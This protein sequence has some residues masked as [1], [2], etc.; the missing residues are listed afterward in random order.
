MNDKMKPFKA[1]VLGLAVMLSALVLLMVKSGDIGDVSVAEANIAR[2][3]I[4]SVSS[5][6]AYDDVDASI[7]IV[8]SQFG[9]EEPLT[10]TLG[11][12]ELNVTFSEHI[13]PPEVHS[14][15]I[16][17]DA[18]S[19]A[20]PAVTLNVTATNDANP[21]GLNAIKYIE[22]EY[23]LGAQKW[24]VVNQSGW[25]DYETSRLNYPWELSTTYG[26]RYM[27]A[28]VKDNDNNISQAPGT[29]VISL[30]P[31][32]VEASIEQDEVHFFRILLEEGENFSATLTP[33]SG[34]PDLY[35]WAANAQLRYDQPLTGIESVSFE[36]PVKGI[37]QIQVYGYT[38]SDYTLSFGTTKNLVQAVPPRRFALTSGMHLPDAPNVSIDRV[39]VSPVVPRPPSQGG[40]SIPVIDRD[41]LSAPERLWTESWPIRVGYQNSGVGL[42]VQHLGNQ[43]TIDQVTVEFRLGSVTGTLLGRSQT[44][45]IGPEEIESSAKVVW[46]PDMPGEYTVCAIIDPDNEV[47]EADESNNTVCRTLTVLP[48]GVDVVL[49]EVDS[50]VI[51]DDA[52]STAS[53]AV[54]LNVTATDYPNPGASGLNA[55]K[56]VE[57]EYI[58]E[59]ERWVPVQRTSWIT[60]TTASLNY[61]WQLISTYGMRYMEAWVADNQGN[62]S[63]TPGV[64]I[65]NY[66]PEATDAS[67]AQ[68]GIHFYC[69]I[70]SQ[71]DI[72]S[73]TLTAS[74]GDPDL[75]V[76][77]PSEQLASYSQ[78]VLTEVD[79]IT[80]VAPNDGTYLIEVHGYQDSDYRLSFGAPLV[81]AVAQRTFAVTGPKPLPDALSMPLSSIPAACPPIRTSDAYEP[82]DS[83]QQASSIATDGTIEAHTFHKRADEDWVRFDGTAGTT[84]SIEARV[85]DDSL[86]DVVLQLYDACGGSSTP[87]DSFGPTVRLQFEAIS[88][89]PHYINLTN[90]DPEATGADVNYQLS[91][92]ALNEEPA[93]G[94][95]VL[96][97]G[98]LRA[99]DRLQSNIHQVTNKVYNLFLQ[100][101]YT[102][103]RIYYLATDF[104]LNADNNPATQDVDALA[105]RERLQYAIT[106]WATDE[107]L[108][109][110]ADR[111]FTLYMMDHGDY[112]TLYLNTSAEQVGPDDLDSWLSTLEAAAPG[113]TVNVIVDACLAG[114]FIDPTLSLSKPG[115]LVIASTTNSSN[116][117]ASQEGGAIFSDSFVQALDQEMSL[118]SAFK[119]AQEVA[120]SW[121]P[122]QVAWLDD[123]GDGQAN[124]NA[125]GQVAQQR[126]FAYAG[127]FAGGQEPP[128][129]AWANG[130]TTIDNRRG[131]IEAHVRDDVPNST[132][133]VWAVIYEPSYTP[134]PPGR[135]IVFEESL[136]TVRLQ[137]PDGDNVY[138]GEFAGFD[139]L[140]SYR[141]VVYAVD[142][143]GLQSRPRTTLVQT[144]Y[145]LYLPAIT[146]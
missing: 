118:Y 23:V 108:G 122:D 134:P 21:G 7:A 55:I 35:V 70:L 129:I 43:Q 67:I 88:S 96:V 97:A 133:N 114:S 105:N 127:S 95:L 117:Y 111:A 40:Q 145:E 71:D 26:T 30:L 62:V 46:E 5:T 80:F 36:A 53:P 132:L 61:P 146:R 14:F 141:I 78:N 15:V 99:N 48:L 69:V 87:Y 84:Y 93:P 10:V 121:H 144:G 42:L 137:D 135:E 12:Q 113:V 58:Y 25:L 91:V 19:T 138:S 3:V 13:M 49:P 125:D 50:F 85:P 1:S 140:G 29:D 136:P 75:Y 2:P 107:S 68:D 63:A 74:T 8:G 112:D 119:E 57:Y 124:G 116:A 101:G 52:P 51:A 54:T 120:Q 104:N 39:P 92:R 76:W 86:A 143:N 32:D 131:Q 47:E 38:A 139:Q 44:N 31:Q 17:D 77:G 83:C 94:A 103:D 72:F 102:A 6:W 59:V 66:L 37:Y 20:S 4:G 73:A 56:Y 82:N 18:T 27:Q 79:S 126:G 89:G 16:A 22:F 123:N 11:T 90:Y 64:D 28:W 115:R 128:Y 109:L 98:R 106:Q 100:H 45:I 142:E 65:I 33:I 34:D 41:L 130:P 81:Q 60:Y 24:V 110:G 9:H